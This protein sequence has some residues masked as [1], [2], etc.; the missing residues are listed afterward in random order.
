MDFL[1]EAV[2]DLIIDDGL[3]VLSRECGYREV[4]CLFSLSLLAVRSVYQ[5]L[6][7][8]MQNIAKYRLH[9]EWRECC[10]YTCCFDHRIENAHRSRAENDDPRC[11][12]VSEGN[13][14][15]SGFKRLLRQL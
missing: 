3:V 11:R 15:K 8:E 9:L 10:T 4:G 12:S 13:H 7:N 5:V 14:V 2:R 1:K 6:R